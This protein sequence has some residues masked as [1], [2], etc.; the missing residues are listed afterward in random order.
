VDDLVADP[1]SA[2]DGVDVVFLAL[3]HGHS[4]ALA[5]AITTGPASPPLLVD[6]GAD[7]RLVSPADWAKFYG[8]DERSHASSW[9]Y[10]LPELP[11]ARQLLAASRTIANP[12]CYPTA[13]A[14][15]MAPLLARGLA[16]P[17]ADVVVVAASGTSGAGRSGST[18]LLGSEVM[19][20][21]AAYRAGGAHQHTPE[22]TQTLSAAAGRTV[23]VSFTPLL[24][25][26]PRGIL[27]TCSVTVAP[28]TGAADARAVLEDA[29][30]AEPFVSVLDDGQWPRTAD[31]LGSNS[32]QIS[33]AVD[34]TAGRL[35]T[36]C[37]ID[38][39]VKGAAGQA[40]Q[41]ANLA[42][43]LDERQGLPRDGVAP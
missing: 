11:G 12:G 42:L 8:P 43:G 31:V 22:M 5:R 38:N 14:L 6:L 41:N 20:S 37:V 9:T 1:S 13:V 26:M 2:L 15:A 40:I 21:V 39:L 29:Y 35:V 33:V 3:P 27:A 10:G 19:G 24:A 16:A 18:A 30:R 28:G 7:H 23:P 32:A 36:V 17:D 25:P 4:A 34:E